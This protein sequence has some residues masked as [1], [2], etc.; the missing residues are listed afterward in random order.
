[1]IGVW[2]CERDGGLDA[3]SNAHTRTLEFYEGGNGYGYDLDQTNGEKYNN[4]SFMW[5]I[6]GN[7]VNVGHNGY[8]YV[9]NLSTVP[10]TMSPQSDK[11]MIFYKE[12]ES[13]SWENT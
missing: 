3:V 4:G 8:A 12:S 9:I 11:S 7:I 13:E 1:M 5:E 6:N 2:T 10:Y